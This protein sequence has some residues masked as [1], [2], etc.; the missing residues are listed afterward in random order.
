MTHGAWK[1]PGAF[2][3]TVSIRLGQ[4]GLK[5]VAASSVVQLLGDRE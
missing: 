3:A 2:G 4:S 1:S 5:P